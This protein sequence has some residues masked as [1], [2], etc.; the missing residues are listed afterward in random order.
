MNARAWTG[1]ALPPLAWFANL[2]ASFVIAPLACSDHGKPSLYVVSFAALLLSITG[3]SLAWS[4][5]KKWGAALGLLFT[6]VIAAQMI[7]N[8]MMAGCE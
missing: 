3:T 4:Q 6:L 8:F 2:E 7:P 1:L 5:H